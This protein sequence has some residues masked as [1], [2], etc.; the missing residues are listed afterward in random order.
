MDGDDTF[1]HDSGPIGEEPNADRA[2]VSTP[3]GG[4]DPPPA[5]PAGPASP[6]MTEVMP[7]PLGL[8]PRHE[9]RTTR[10]GAE[11]LVYHALRRDLPEGW[12]AWHSLRIRGPERREGEGDFVV[13]IPDRGALLLEVKG[14]RVEL[15]D[16]RWFQSGRLLQPSPREQGHGYIK[17]LLPR[18]QSLLGDA[19]PFVT[20][21]SCFP[22]TAFDEEPT[23]DDVRGALIGAQDLPHLGATLRRLADTLFDV[24]KPPPE[25]VPWREALHTLWC[26][27][28]T[29]A[30]SLGHRAALR[31]EE[32]V[33]LDETQVALLDTV[34]ESPRMLVLGGP[35]T[36]K[37]IV[38]RELYRRWKKAGR[39]PLYLCSTSALAAELRGHGLTSASTV[40]DHAAALLDAADLE[41]QDGARP[42]EWTSAHWELAPLR[43]ANEALP[44][45]GR[46]HDG[47]LVDEGQDFT[48]NDW[49]LVRAL[50]GGGPLWI[51]A[52]EGQ[53]FWE[54]R[55]LP[56]LGFPRFRLKERYRC[57]EGLARFADHY[58]K[59]ATEADLEE[60]VAGLGSN[61]LTVV[62]LAPEHE[63]EAVLEAL[64]DLLFSQKADP[65]DVAVLCLPGKDRS[66]LA[67][68]DRLGSHRVVRADAPDAGE[69]VVADTFLRFKGLDRPYCILV[70][71]E[72]AAERYDVR[73]HIALTRATTGA[74]VVARHD[75]V[76]KDRRLAAAH[77][78]RLS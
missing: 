55:P 22:Q 38:M 75:T 69:H 21:A 58:R 17:K 76:E 14:G 25:G 35:G 1:G 36:G 41:L 8:Y 74:I 34:D 4:D 11:H 49:A 37:T 5:R 66:R 39:N 45:L 29:P 23:A 57:P 2:R 47:V 43:A 78:L 9:P 10:S 32:M 72:Q 52:D 15:R 28:W 51:A 12:T 42:H 7:V 31:E 6:N 67:N 20:L 26:E 63:P 24:T 40:K 56:D 68:A 3:E 62:T 44:K 19:L 46:A 54:D 70:D 48:A 16:G 27:T 53:S 77:A 73:M 60:A 65:R 33:A 18:L 13:A 50:A 71:L 61:E 30:L 59:D 64:L